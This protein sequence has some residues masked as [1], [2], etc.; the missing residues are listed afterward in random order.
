MWVA[1]LPSIENFRSPIAFLLI[2]S[3]PQN[4]KNRCVS[5]PS[6]SA[7]LARIRP[8]SAGHVVQLV[9]EPGPVDEVGAHVE[10]DGP[11][12]V[13]RDLPLVEGDQDL[14]LGVDLLDHEVGL[15]VHLALVEHASQVRGG[16]RLR[17]RA[18]ERRHVDQLD[19]VA[20]ALLAQPGFGQER[21]LQWRDGA[22]DR[23][24]VM[25]TTSRPP[26]KV[27]RAFASASAPSS[28]SKSKMLRRH[29]EPSMPGVWSGRGVVPEA[30]TSWS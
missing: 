6:P 14:P 29:S 28:V 26:S 15:D 9:A 11:Q 25:W 19:P 2:M 13:E 20:H 1:V 27:V 22:L 21:E 18:V 7:A 4:V 8:G 23:V 16:D 12:Q 30:I 5:M 24:S 10:R 17:E 3:K